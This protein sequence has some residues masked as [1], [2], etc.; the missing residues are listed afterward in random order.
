M[1][2]DLLNQ[3]NITTLMGTGGQLSRFYGSGNPLSEVTHKRRLSALG[4]GGLV[5]ARWF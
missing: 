2:Y 5:K 3:N 4:E 1:P